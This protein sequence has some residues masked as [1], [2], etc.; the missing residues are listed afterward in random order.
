VDHPKPARTVGDQDVA[1]GR[2]RD[3]VRVDQT[4]G[5]FDDAEVVQRAPHDAG[6]RIG[7]LGRGEGG[8]GESEPKPCRGY[9]GDTEPRG[10]SASLSRRRG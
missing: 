3:R 4:V 5:D 9:G 10:A 6:P 1:L 7:L 2:E 8:A